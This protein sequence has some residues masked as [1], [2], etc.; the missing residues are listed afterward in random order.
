[1]V[2]ICNDLICPNAC[3]QKAVERGLIFMFSS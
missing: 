3:A 2:H 1:M